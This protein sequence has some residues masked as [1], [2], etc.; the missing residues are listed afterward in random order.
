MKLK[1]LFQPIY[2]IR[3]ARYKCYEL[4]HPGRPW[5]AKRAVQF[6]DEYLSKE[7][8]GLEWGSGRSTIYFGQRLKTLLSIEHNPSWYSTIKGQLEEKGY[9]HI[10]YRYVPLDHD[11]GEPTIP[12]Y[13]NLPKYVRVAEEFRDETLDFVVVDGHYRQACI[14]AVLPKLKSGGLLLVDN[15]NWLPLAEWQVPP[16]W[17][18][19]HQSTYIMTET[20]IWQKP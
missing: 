3:R 11:P 5:I 2:V 12:H 20:T 10:D 15:T 13:K 8:I 7:H 9:V 14:L 18:V 16:S 4:C 1:Y 6:C 19:V 17:P